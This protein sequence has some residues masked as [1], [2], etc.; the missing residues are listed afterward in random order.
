[1]RLIERPRRRG[2]LGQR[3]EVLRNRRNDDA[4]RHADHRRAGKMARAA[5]IALQ[6][7]GLVAVV[8]VAG[9]TGVT[10]MLA[11]VLMRRCGIRVAVRHVLTERH[12]D[13]DH[14]LERQ[15]ERHQQY[16]HR[17]EPTHRCSI[18]ESPSR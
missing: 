18:Y 3:A 8:G 10:M 16:H 15:P 9:G 7:E 17:P 13:R 2:R 5:V 11:V 6:R 14:R 12:G 1:M 4:C